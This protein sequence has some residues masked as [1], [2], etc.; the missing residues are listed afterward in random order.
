MPSLATCIF[1]PLP[2]ACWYFL[3]FSSRWFYTIASRTLDVIRV[4]L[5]FMFV[6]NICLL[7]IFFQYNFLNKYKLRDI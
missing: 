3:Y 1:F 4:L 7:K 6:A 5:L 2:V